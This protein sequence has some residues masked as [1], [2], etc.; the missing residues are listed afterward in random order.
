VRANGGVVSLS[1][2]V[3]DLM[4]SAQASSVAWQVHGVK[5]VKHDL[6][7]KEKI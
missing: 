3:V 4:M 2:E 1:G 6:T 7:V 5:S